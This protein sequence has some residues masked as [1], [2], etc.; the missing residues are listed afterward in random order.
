MKDKDNG[1]LEAA[2]ISPGKIECSVF[3]G[4]REET[5]RGERDS[6]YL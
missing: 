4:R 2:Q 5:T 1:S 3:E 6:K